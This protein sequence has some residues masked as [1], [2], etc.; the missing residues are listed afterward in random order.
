MKSRAPE[1]RRRVTSKCSAEVLGECH[2]TRA[3]VSRNRH[4][5]R[6]HVGNE[7]PQLQYTATQR[8]RQRKDPRT[9]NACDVGFVQNCFCF[10]DLRQCRFLSSAE[11]STFAWASPL[12]NV[13]VS[14]M[15]GNERLWS[16]RMVTARV[17]CTVVTKITPEFGYWFFSL[18]IFILLITG[19]QSGVLHASK[20]ELG[21]ST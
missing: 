11:F 4:A 12:R 17:G 7:I 20:L 10:F 13:S 5:F 15:L 8:S 9:V 18:E 14:P 3:R 16:G 19:F 21:R 1:A 6:K 2:P